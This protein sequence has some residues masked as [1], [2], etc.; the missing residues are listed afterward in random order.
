MHSVV[1]LFV[2]F[3]FPILLFEVERDSWCVSI[4]DDLKVHLVFL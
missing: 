3:F 1:Y 4:V 2:V